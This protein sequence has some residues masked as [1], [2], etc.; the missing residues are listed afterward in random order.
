M[1]MKLADLLRDLRAIETR[2][3]WH[4]LVDGDPESPRVRVQKD[5]ISREAFR[6]ALQ[7]PAIAKLLDDLELPEADHE[8][9]F[10]VL[11]ADGSNELDIEELVTGIVRVRGQARSMDTV[12]VRLKVDELAK[13]VREDMQKKEDNLKNAIQQEFSNFRKLLRKNDLLTSQRTLSREV[14][15]EISQNTRQCRRTDT[16][17]SAVSDVSGKENTPYSKRISS[18]SN[19]ST[20]VNIPETADLDDLDDLDDLEK[21]VDE[22]PLTDMLSDPNCGKDTGS[23]DAA[24]VPTATVIPNSDIFNEIAVHLEQL[25]NRFEDQSD[26]PAVEQ[27]SSIERKIEELK[28]GLRV[29][30]VSNRNPLSSMGQSRTAFIDHTN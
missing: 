18:L 17:S 5:T 2:T 15:R 12:A 4:H 10:D 27:L 28:V 24:E 22:T 16:V 3:T 26:F 20:T 23:P 21:L 6:T 9:L 7:D 30:F 14:S 1:A 19:L 11:D 25:R 8:Q 13:N 29:D